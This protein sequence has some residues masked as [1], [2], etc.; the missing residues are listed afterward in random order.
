MRCNAEFELGAGEV[1]MEARVTSRS[2]NIVSVFGLAILVVGCGNRQSSFDA[3]GIRAQ[4]RPAEAHDERG[5]R[6]MSRTAKGQDLLYIS[7]SGIYVLSYP[8]GKLVGTIYDPF[9]SSLCSDRQ[10]N[11]FVIDG[12]Y[13]QIT[14]YPHGSL[15]P[16]ATL[17]VNAEPDDCAVD[18][19][20]DNLAVTTTGN[21]SFATVAIFTKEHG[22]PRYYD[23]VEY[24]GFLESC[25]FDDR[26]NLLMLAAGGQHSLAELPQGAKAVRTITLEATYKSTELAS[27]QWDGKYFALAVD[28]SD[29]ETIDRIVIKGT[30]AHIVGQSVLDQAAATDTVFYRGNVIA[31]TYSGTAV[32]NYPAGGDPVR[33]LYSV[34]GSFALSLAAPMRKAALP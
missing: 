21:G 12:G 34:G 31:K 23:Y 7:D 4:S 30:K 28:G 32:W 5:A 14:E 26:S 19:K 22:R 6:W 2:R 25:T 27:V 11:V 9:S 24:G 8:A 20:T 10:G 1:H 13:S 16:I 29:A 15:T 3:L 17:N 33:M 18:P